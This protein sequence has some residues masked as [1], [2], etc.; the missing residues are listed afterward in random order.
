MGL[1]NES[2]LRVV[3]ATAAEYGERF[4]QDLLEQYKVVRGRIA[5]ITVDRDRQNRFLLAI[6]TAL[7]AV[8][9]LLVKNWFGGN[10]PA[11]FEVLALLPFFLMGALFSNLWVLWN[12]TFRE[13]LRAGY[14]LLRGMERYLPAQPFEVELAYRNKEGRGKHTSTADFIILVGQIFLGL[15]VLLAFAALCWTVCAVM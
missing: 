14:E 12:R 7:L 8:P 1:S 11:P 13:A 2:D 3:H 5:D 6:L 15:N 9:S 10:P 4:Q